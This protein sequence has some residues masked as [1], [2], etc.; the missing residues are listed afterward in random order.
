LTSV[1]VE[2]SQSKS[3]SKINDEQWFETC[4]L[5][6]RRKGTRVTD[7][8][9]LSPKLANNA[10]RNFRDFPEFALE[11]SK[12]LGNKIIPLE[13]FIGSKS[14]LKTLSN[15]TYGTYLGTDTSTYL[16]SLNGNC[17]S[18][19][20][21]V[22][23]AKDYMCNLLLY[24]DTIERVFKIYL[25]LVGKVPEIA[26]RPLGTNN[27]D[28]SSFGSIYDSESPAYAVAQILDTDDGV[29]LPS[30]LGLSRSSVFIRILVSM[31]KIL[32]TLFELGS[33]K[34]FQ[35]LASIKLLLDSLDSDFEKIERKFDVKKVV[36]F[37]VT[38]KLLK[39]V[40]SLP[41]KEND[42]RLHSYLFKCPIGKHLEIDITLDVREDNQGKIENAISC[43][44]NMLVKRNKNINSVYIMLL[45]L[46]NKT[47]LFH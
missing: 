36:P 16:S 17:F 43:E 37:Q 1:G 14:F 32:S 8:S 6:A 31:D 9:R 4:S 7:V 5:V 46:E 23:Q 29:V 10:R 41:L 3:L 38:T 34:L 30:P 35:D 25:D 45:N 15:S 40:S 18:F 44:F 11:L 39:G 24:C 2:I 13:H 21:I 12:R 19:R 26:S 42:E 33:N 22:P 28:L 27:M 47:N 20:G